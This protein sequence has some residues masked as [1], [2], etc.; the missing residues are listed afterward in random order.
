M[1]HKSAYEIRA[2]LLELAFNILSEQQCA[3]AGRGA[4]SADARVSF[5][6]SAPSTADVIAEAEK[7]NNFVSK[8]EDRR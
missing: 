4:K 2:S 5:I 3:K 6:T 7:L 1:Q 8:K